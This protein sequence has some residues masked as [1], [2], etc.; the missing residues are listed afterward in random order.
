MFPQHNTPFCPFSPVVCIY[1]VCLSFT[2]FPSFSLR[3]ILFFSFFLHLWWLS[4]AMSEQKCYTTAEQEEKK[5][6]CVNV[7]VVC[8]CKRNAIPLSFCFS[9]GTKM[10]FPCT[11]SLSFHFS[12]MPC[13]I[14]HSSQSWRVNLFLFHTH[15]SPYF[16]R[17]PTH[18]LPSYASRLKD[19]CGNHYAASGD[20][21]PFCC[22]LCRKTST[23]WN[24]TCTLPSRVWYK[25]H[26]ML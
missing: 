25:R 19:N 18:L 5:Y 26:T 7:V 8:N 3:V 21:M 4:L 9:V 24:A 12:Q 11:I 15:F 23:C 20:M 13:V 10:S 2:F 1:A 17:A 14:Q 16:Y 22:L 6:I